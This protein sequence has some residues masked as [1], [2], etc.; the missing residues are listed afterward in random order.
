[1][2]GVRRSLLSGE[3]EVCLTVYF[4]GQFW[5]G[6]FEEDS[7]EGFLV[8]RHLFGAEPPDIM[9][10]ELVQRSMPALSADRRRLS[11]PDARARERTRGNPK[12]LAREA[13]AALAARGASTR[14]QEALKMRQEER[15]TEARVESREQR[16]RDR[17]RKR[18]LARAKALKK[19]RGH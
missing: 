16:E 13:S 19:H 17:E 10:L 6:V 7:R 8:G 12:W 3:G 1:M 5:V 11:G 18:N 4:D 15:K 9:I 2:S 14:S